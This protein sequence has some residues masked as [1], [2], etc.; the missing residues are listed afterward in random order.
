VLD[1]GEEFSFAATPN[2]IP[3]VA[4]RWVVTNTSDEQSSSI[5]AYDIWFGGAPAVLATASGEVGFGSAV[6]DGDLAAWTENQGAATRLTVVDLVSGA[7]LWTVERA[8]G[9]LYPVDLD[10]TT[11]VYVEVPREWPYTVP[12]TVVAVD[13]ATGA[14]QSFQASINTHEGGYRIT[15][16]GRFVIFEG[17]PSGY[18]LQQEVFFDVPANG[19]QTDLQDG[20]LAWA[21]VLDVERGPTEVHMAPA[22]EFASGERSR[23]FPETDQWVSTSFLRFWEAGGGLPTFGYPLET[24]WHVGSDLRYFER[25]VMEWHPEL[26]GTVYEIELSRLGADALA[27]QGLDWTTFPQADPA[28]PHYQA[29]TGHAIA[30]EFWTYWSGHGLEFG[31]PGVSFHESL[32]LFGYPL[33]EGYTDP[34]TGLLTQYFERAVFEYYPQNAGTAYEVLLRRLGAEALAAQG[35]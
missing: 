18:D 27:R 22:A 28:T 4:A 32:A 10:G 11:L 6:V 35:W 17:T 9:R 34:A 21:I 13:L 1:S 15:T 24:P 8:D 12:H 7:T 25:Q 5:L 14:T 29:V 23:Y 26:T 20:L 31:H 19:H 30:P 2:W 33:S 3:A 16:D